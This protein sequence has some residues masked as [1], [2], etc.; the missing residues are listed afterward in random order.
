MDLNVTV[1]QEVVQDFLKRYSEW[2][3]DE[4]TTPYL[5]LSSNDTCYEAE[6]YLLAE[7]AIL[8]SSLHNPLSENR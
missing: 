8:A 4:E 7:D 6:A 2:N 5:Y 3:G 1:P